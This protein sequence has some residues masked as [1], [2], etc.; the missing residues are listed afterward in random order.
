MSDGLL[1]IGPTAPGIGEVVT[2]GFEFDVPARFE[3]SVDEW[4]GIRADA[5]A[6]WSLGEIACV[7]VLDEVEYPE[8]WYP[9]GY[10]NWGALG[11]DFTMALAQGSLHVV[12]PSTAINAFLPAPPTL[13]PGGSDIFTV[14]VPAGA[15]GSIQLRDDAGTAVGSAFG[16][17]NTKR[18]GGYVSGGTF[19]W[20][21]Y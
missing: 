7:E 3:L 21:V 14:V 18:V 12:T 4:Q 17:G 9:G 19:T 8:L 10:T 16:A 15:A 1:T 20:V 2:A 13:F 6:V 5:F 11:V